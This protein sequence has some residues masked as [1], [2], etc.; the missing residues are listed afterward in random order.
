MSERGAISRR[1]M[2]KGGTIGEDHLIITK[3]ILFV[4]NL[5]IT[6]RGANPIYG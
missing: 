5:L 3:L 2:E 4:P 1:E 6:L